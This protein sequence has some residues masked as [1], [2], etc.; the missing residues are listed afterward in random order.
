MNAEKYAARRNAFRTGSILLIFAFIAT[1][2]LVATFD[3]TRSAIAHN[4]QQAKRALIDQ[5]LA[6][7]PC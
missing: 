2:L 5:V 6:A 7:V 3:T 1:A 4:E